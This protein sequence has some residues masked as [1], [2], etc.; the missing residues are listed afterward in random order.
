MFSSARATIKETEPSVDKKVKPVQLLDRM[1]SRIKCKLSDIP[2]SLV[3]L[4]LTRRLHDKCGLTV[5]HFGRVQHTV[6]GKERLR[7]EKQS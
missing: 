1:I 5:A 6:G 2:C 3:F 4:Y 7:K